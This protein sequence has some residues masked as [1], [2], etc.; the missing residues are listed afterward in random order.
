MGDEYVRYTCR[1]RCKQWLGVVVD[2]GVVV[3][4]VE[5]W[6]VLRLMLGSG[7]R[8]PRVVLCKPAA[9]FEG[10]KNLELV[11]RMETA[12]QDYRQQQI[13]GRKK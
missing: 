9:C 4:G 2:K 6:H 7:R 8:T 11:Q 1:D 10:A 5:H 3:E 12:Y 13:F